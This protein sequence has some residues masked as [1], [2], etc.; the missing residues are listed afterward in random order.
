MEE[1]YGS[2]TVKGVRVAVLAAI[3]VLCGS[4]I[5]AQPGDVFVPYVEYSSN[6]YDNLLRLQDEA[7]ALSRFGS[8]KLSDTYTTAVGGMRFDQT[9]GRQHVTADLSENSNH[10]DHFS[11]YD[12]VGKDG[13]ANWNW[14]LGNHLQGNLAS[15]YSQSLVPFTDNIVVVQNV[16]NIRTQRTNSA[17]LAWLI[18]PSWRLRTAYARYDLVYSSDEQG[19]NDQRSD[20]AELGLSYLARS[21]SNIGLVF[22]NIRGSYDGLQIIGD[23]SY[24]NNYV[25]KELKVSVNWLVTGQSRLQFL[26]GPVQRKR[27]YFTS[28]DYSGF[29]ARLTATSQTTG[30]LSLNASLWRE[31]GAL[32][33]LD[34]NYALT[35][36]VS[37][38][39]GLLISSKFYLDGSATYQR[40]DYS[41]AQVIEGLTPSN[42]R[43]TYQ[44][45]AVDL[46]YR[47]GPSLSLTTTVSREV[48]DSNLTN[49]SYRANG[50]SLRLRYEF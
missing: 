50:V 28:R 24:N 44:R 26:G 9:W 36:G 40:L 43:D 46:I 2:R 42:R 22:R 25:Q 17:D 8:T 11:Q 13:R 45:T 41:G 29:N 39:P 37:F 38:A 4:A 18:H 32:D 16:R 31:L 21:G 15:T 33:D 6:Y 49:F 3:N 19:A 20:T 30:K 5:A 23:Q 48:R 14:V 1:K 10:Y 7:V 34:A 35:D 47:A 12:Y 27:E